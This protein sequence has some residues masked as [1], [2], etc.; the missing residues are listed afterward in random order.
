MV[1]LLSGLTGV[2]LA[3]D[4]DAADGFRKGRKLGGCER[5]VQRAEVF[6]EVGEFGRAG[7]GDDPRALGLQP[8]RGDLRRVEAAWVAEIRERLDQGPVGFAGFSPA[9]R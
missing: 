7:M 6:L 9:A 3:D 5:E 2:A 4:G 8:R 1:D